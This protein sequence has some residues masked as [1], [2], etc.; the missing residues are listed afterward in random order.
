MTSVTSEKDNDHLADIVGGVVLHWLN[1]TKRFLVA[2]A[3]AGNAKSHGS[4]IPGLSVSQTHRTKDEGL[5]PD[6]RVVRFTEKLNNPGTMVWLLEQQEPKTF[7][8]EQLRLTS[9]EN[10]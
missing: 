9:R 6:M 4:S 7:N 2:S 1:Q 10:S 5:L 8:Y 3:G